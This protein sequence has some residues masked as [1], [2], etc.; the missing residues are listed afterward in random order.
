MSILGMIIL[1]C[2]LIG[3]A[4][5]SGSEW[6]GGAAMTLALFVLAPVLLV[7]ILAIAIGIGG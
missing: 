4:T 1:I 3:N 2:L 5:D 6:Q 7:L